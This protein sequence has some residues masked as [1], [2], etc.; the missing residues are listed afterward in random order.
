MRV[1]RAVGRIGDERGAP[2]YLV[3]GV[4]RDLLLLR[5]AR[6]LDVLVVGDATAVARSLAT[7]FGGRVQR[8]AAFGTATVHAERGLK[9]DLA[10]SRRERYPRPAALPVV[11]P[12]TLEEDLWRRD[13]GVNALALSLGPRRVGG[14]VDPCGG[15]D[16]LKR[17]R[18][19][20]LHD[21]SFEDDP[22]RAFRAVRLGWR[23]RFEIEPATARAIRGA[24][25]AGL[26]DALSGRRLSREVELA[27][28]EPR[29]TELAR[30]LRRYRL[31][32][33]LGCGIDPR[34]EDLR[35]LGR[36]ERLL[37]RYERLTRG[38]PVTRWDVA[39]AALAWEIDAGERDLLIH[40]L[41]PGR[42]TARLLGDG[43][44][45]ARAI[46]SEL[47]GARRIRPSHVRAACRDAPAEVVLL[48]AAAARGER[49]PGML[50]TWLS[51]WR[52]VRSQIDGRDLLRAGILPGPAV[53]RGLEAALDARLDG[54]ARG[55]RAELR[56]AISAAGGA[57][58]RAGRT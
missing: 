40:R 34:T 57:E 44:R 48:A 16:D 8:H 56:A 42:R 55:R 9:L 19:R 33:A 1:L 6:D 4:V 32:S 43:V 14:L 5:P 50:A 7:L 37:A 39:L 28:G 36:L 29:A 15:L 47:S 26:F 51:R 27:L 20:V 2:V 18:I 58:R 41:R 25:T 46:V 53:A 54:R 31:W 3:G 30:E 10:S 11:A 24:V 52:H 22:T 12:G 21:R 23:L 45:R 13:F 35:R 17:K 38:E 49:L